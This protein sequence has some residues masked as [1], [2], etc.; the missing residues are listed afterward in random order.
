M[1][2]HVVG[3]QK[4]QQD[5]RAPSE[6]S[7]S[8]KQT[9]T[10][11]YYTDQSITVPQKIN[12][13]ATG[14]PA[15]NSVIAM[16]GYGDNIVATVDMIKASP[17]F[18]KFVPSIKDA[19][20]CFA[21]SSGELN[22]EGLLHARPDVAFIAQGSRGRQFERLQ[23]MGIPVA[24]LKANAMKNLLDRTMITGE[25]LGED[26]YQ[27]ALKYVEYFNHNV[28]RVS[29]RISQIPK[30]RRA[31]V[32]HAM[33]NPLMTNAGPSL[34]QD[35][36]DLAGVINIAQDWR[37]ANTG[38][39]GHGN[40]NLE[41][42]I[43]ADPDVILCMDVVAAD[44]IKT[45]PAWG[46]IKAVKDGR[47]YVNPKGLFVWCRETSEEALQF[48]WLAKTVYPTD[49]ADIDIAEETRSFYK[50]FYGYDLSDDDVQLFL[51]PKR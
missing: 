19:V 42:I 2:W 33:G 1:V 35:W 29:Q 34:V 26:A 14:W 45:E 9:R 28:R 21:T 17:I 32:Y 11:T 3:C 41:E 48:L 25:I 7:G 43:A 37:I 30:K 16:L 12:R 5:R 47:V 8:S 49:F 51:N 40:A 10:I 39:S 23:E 31:R 18:N 6:S 4:E 13:V 20:V 22:I 15:Q 36:M 27:R 44:F 50:N 38:M 24:F 46:G